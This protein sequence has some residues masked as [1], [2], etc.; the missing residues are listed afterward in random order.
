MEKQNMQKKQNQEKSQEEKQS[1]MGMMNKKERMQSMKM[2]GLGMKGCCPMC[3]K[4]QKGNMG[5]HRGKGPA[6][7]NDDQIKSE[8][9]RFLTED[10]WLDA[11]DIQVS[12]KNGVVTLVGKVDEWESKRHAED[13]ALHVM[14]VND[15]KNNLTIHSK[16]N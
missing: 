3:G 10:S 11:S 15:V 14:G 9:E 4:K 2:K 13:L 6:Q 12:S 8:I 5:P 16:E 7:P 1:G